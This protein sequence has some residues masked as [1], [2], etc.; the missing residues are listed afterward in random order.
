MRPVATNSTN[1]EIRHSERYSVWPA[2]LLSPIAAG[3]NSKYMS[4]PGVF[5][6]STQK[7][8]T[9]PNSPVISEQIC[10]PGECEFPIPFIPT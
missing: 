8:N 3:M 1:V 7:M 2:A 10:P 4:T 9:A 6:F 5:L